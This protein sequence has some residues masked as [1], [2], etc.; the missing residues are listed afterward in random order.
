MLD[1][2]KL[3]LGITDDERDDLLTLILEETASR[4]SNRYLAGNAVPEALEYIVVAVSVIRY[5]RI[6]SEGMSAQTIE[7]E[8]LH[9]RDNDFEAYEDD[10]AGWLAE[11]DDIDS[12]AGRV[13]FI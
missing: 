6:G 9:F 7:G 12:G 2:L 1:N 4:L 10:I 3:L 5:N 8:A 13:K 11:Q